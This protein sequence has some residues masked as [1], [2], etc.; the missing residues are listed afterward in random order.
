[1]IKTKSLKTIALVFVLFYVGA[2]LIIALGNEFTLLNWFSNDDAFYYFKIAQNIGE[3]AGSSFDG[4]N[5]TN[6]YHPLWMLICI[7]IFTIARFNLLLPLRLVII[8]S[9]FF[10]AGASILLFRLLD[11][12]FNQKIALVGAAFWAFSP[13]IIRPV[14]M[15]GLESPI[16]AFF[17]I[18]L[19]ERILAYNGSAHLNKTL[20]KKIIILGCIATLTVLSRLDNIFIVFFAGV[21]IWVRWWHEPGTDQQTSNKM[22]WLWR[23]KTGFAYYGPITLVVLIYMGWNQLVFN[24]PMPI[25]GQVKIWWGSLTYTVYGDAPRY[26]SDHLTNFF[27]NNKNAP[28]FLVTP[29]LHKFGE[30]VL[31]WFGQ[32]PANLMVKRFLFIIAGIGVIITGFIYPYKT[33]F[34]KKV[35]TLELIPFFLGCLAQITYYQVVGSVGQRQWYWVSEY[36]FTILFFC[37]LVS[38]MLK[39]FEKNMNFE[40]ISKGF[41]IAI[42]IYFIIV[43]LLFIQSNRYPDQPS[44]THPYNVHTSVIRSLLDPGTMI[45]LTG[46]GHTGYL[47]DDYPVVNLDGLVNNYEYFQALKSHTVVYYLTD[48]G[49]EYVIGSESIIFQSSPY[50]QNFKDHLELIPGEIPGL[51]P[52]YIWRL[53]TTSP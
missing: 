21:W 4:I 40:V 22:K 34:F 14:L 20:I 11:R 51:T 26:L 52:R 6:G 28:W 29:W 7:P 2:F 48:I 41:A 44:D 42:G 18:L 17:I 32:D 35:I 3:G 5:L 38:V 30:S 10:Y 43:H 23:I 33:F 37:L 53:K 15:G 8:V 1:M 9:A 49:L 47:L 36:I 31:V 46:S 27:S 50:K 25:S 39:Y 12:I 45:G 13:V 16:N 19:W 24:T